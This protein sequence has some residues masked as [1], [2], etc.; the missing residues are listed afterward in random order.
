MRNTLFNAEWFGHYVRGARHDAGFKNAKSFSNAI[1]EKTGVFIDKDTIL[2]I[3]RGERLPDVEKYYAIVATI[4]DSNNLMQWQAWADDV[5]DYC[6]DGRSVLL[7]TEEDIMLSE[8]QLS[9][10]TEQYAHILSMPHE[11]A[12]S[13]FAPCTAICRSEIDRVKESAQRLEDATMQ[14][15][16][17]TLK[18]N[19]LL[20]RARAALSGLEKVSK[21]IHMFPGLTEYMNDMHRANSKAKPAR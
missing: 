6:L 2:L 21:D 10:L 18:K 4:S 5:L 13:C 3:E 14:S 12:L 20:E 15:E 9:T 1:E 17:D 16:N 19:A 11:T 7:V 8:K